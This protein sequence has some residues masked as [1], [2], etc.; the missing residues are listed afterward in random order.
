MFLGQM[1]RDLRDCYCINELNLAL[2]KWLLQVA[3]LALYVAEQL[4]L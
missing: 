1:L 2:E 3:E 4:V